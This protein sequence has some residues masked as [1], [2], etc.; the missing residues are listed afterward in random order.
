MGFIC[1]SR[2]ADRK[3]HRS[4]LHRHRSWRPLLR[5]VPAALRL[6]RVHLESPVPSTWFFTTST[7]SSAW[8]LRACC[9]PLPIMRFA[10][11]R[12]RAD[13]SP[14]VRAGRCGREIPAAHIV[15]L[16]GCS[17]STAVPRHR[18]RCPPA[19]GV[20]PA[21]PPLQRPLSRSMRRWLQTVASASGPC[22]VVGSAVV[23]ASLPMR[24]Q[25]GPSLGLGS[26][27][28]PF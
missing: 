9:I 26:L 6:P 4:P 13:R 24:T 23:T 11:F 19:V 7:A 12:A 16:E 22:S 25:P 2:P 8:S 1:V 5:D 10:A 28:G 27:Q 18:G 14:P 3:A 15:P 17:P 21:A 20:P